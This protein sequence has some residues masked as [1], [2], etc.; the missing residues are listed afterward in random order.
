MYSRP[1]FSL[2]CGLESRLCT[3]VLGSKDIRSIL[4]NTFVDQFMWIVLS[5]HYRAIIRPW[6][7]LLS[8]FWAK[9]APKRKN[10]APSFVRKSKMGVSSNFFIVLYLYSQSQYLKFGRFASLHF[11]KRW[12][13][14]SFWLRRP[15]GG[16]CRTALTVDNQLFSRPWQNLSKLY[17]KWNLFIAKWEKQKVKWA[18]W[19][20]G[21]IVEQK[22]KVK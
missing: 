1:P 17:S 3:A 16:T 22:S 13:E 11:K 10:F 14:A 9:W 20:R 15:R 7:N 4:C 6:Q 5:L 18:K 12:E 21:R 8:K 19:A 2:P